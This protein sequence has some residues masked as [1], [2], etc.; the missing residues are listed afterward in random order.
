MSTNLDEQMELLGF[1]SE[2]NVIDLVIRIKLVEKE[3][4]ALKHT[5]NKRVK[6]KLVDMANGKKVELEN[7]LFRLTISAPKESK[8]V[9]PISELNKLSPEIKEQIMH[10]KTST[11]MVRITIREDEKE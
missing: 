3:L 10:M 8:K 11:P 2:N 4:K 7:D 9:K 6:E 5:Y 1:M